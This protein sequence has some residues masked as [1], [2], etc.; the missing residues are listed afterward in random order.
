M[1]D[2]STHG[3]TVSEFFTNQPL[4]EMPVKVPA[5]WAGGRFSV[6]DITRELIGLCAE[7]AGSIDESLGWKQLAML[8]MAQYCQA[9]PPWLSALLAGPDAYFQHYGV[10]LMEV[11]GGGTRW[12]PIKQ[13]AGWLMQ[14]GYEDMIL[15]R[16]RVVYQQKGGDSMIGM[17]EPGGNSEPDPI[18]PGA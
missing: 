5:H 7:G 8:I 18:L 11:S 6:E 1:T 3:V 13:A 4:I 17:N 2:L 9:P 14:G 15:V 12:L 10:E 16:W